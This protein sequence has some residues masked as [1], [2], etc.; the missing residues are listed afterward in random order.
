MAGVRTSIAIVA[1]L[2]GC[3]SS[4]TTSTIDTLVTDVRVEREALVVRA[5]ATSLEATSTDFILDDRSELSVTER[6]GACTYAKHPIPVL[7][8]PPPRPLPPPRPPS[9]AA[10]ATVGSP[11]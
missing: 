4:T 5:C 9:P 8:P 2:A 1:T 3:W 11:P 10:G 7:L 6:R